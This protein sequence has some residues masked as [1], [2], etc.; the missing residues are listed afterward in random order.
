MKRKIFCAFALLMLNYALQA[1]VTQAS[2]L[3]T[4]DD[5]YNKGILYGFSGLV[6]KDMEKAKGYFLQSIALGKIKAHYELANIYALEDNAESRS[7]AIFHFE[8]A[9]QSGNADAWLGLGN[10]FYKTNIEQ[11]D[12][13]KAFEYYKKGADLNNNNCLAFVGYFYFKGLHGQQDYKMAFDYFTKASLKDNPMA[14]YFLGLQYR[15]GYGVERN[16][17]LARTLLIKSASYNHF[18]AIKELEI[19]EPEN[20]TTPVVPPAII[21]LGQVNG[22]T[23]TKHNMKPGS[24]IGMYKG[25]AIRYDFSG[26]NILSVFP[27][28]VNFNAIGNNITGTWKEEG[29]DTEIQATYSESGL[30]FSNTKQNKKDHYS[31]FK[32]GEFWQFN[33]A[34]FN[35]LQQKDETFITGNIQQY[36][37]A[38]KEPGRPLYIHLSRA[39]TIE[40]AKELNKDAI[41]LAC[42]SPFTKNIQ[43]TFKITQTTPVALKMYSDQGIVVFNQNAGTLPAGTYTR[44][45]SIASN[46]SS[47]S[48]IL[49]LETKMDNKSMIIIKQ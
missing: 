8:K 48:Y 24:I 34:K 36:S 33:N 16:I 38:R 21:Q 9:A 10:L 35:L 11:Q 6:L 13:T 46:I 15:N 23:R 47:G 40:E 20:R 44:N 43:V 17:S 39:T 49:K 37:N 32:G 22:Y 41:T 28:E 42:N 12:F 19:K 27:L 18:Q 14:F 2:Q 45:F 4:A 7:K 31:E 1:Q 5:A 26:K 30:V 25:Y 3:L 29:V